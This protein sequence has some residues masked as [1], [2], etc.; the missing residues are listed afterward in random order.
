MKCVLMECHDQEKEN[1]G[2]IVQSVGKAKQAM[3]KQTNNVED[4]GRGGRW[5]DGLLHFGSSDVSSNQEGESDF[6]M[7]WMQYVVQEE[8]AR[9]V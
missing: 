1:E 7:R 5:M 3:T 8:R 4:E 9:K 6:I 2:L